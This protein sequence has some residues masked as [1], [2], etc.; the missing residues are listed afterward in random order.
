MSKENDIARRAVVMQD[1][2]NKYYLAL[3]WTLEELN[4]EKDTSVLDL[5][6]SLE[7]MK[8]SMINVF[9]IKNPHAPRV[10][11]ERDI[12]NVAKELGKTVTL[13]FE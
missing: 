13:E 1:K 10:E 5:I 6:I 9:M 3:G 2:I 12:D 8:Q 11:L 4:K 7:M